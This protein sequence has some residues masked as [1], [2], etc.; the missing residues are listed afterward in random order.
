MSDELSDL[1]HTTTTEGAS[2]EFVA[3]LRRLLGEEMALART[4]TA[5]LNEHPEEVDDRDFEIV[6]TPTR[7]QVES[8]A[9][10]TRSS[11]WWMQIAAAMIG[12][13]VI[14][15]VLVSLNRSDSELDTVDIP[16]ETI[17][18]SPPPDVNSLGLD[19]EPTALTMTSSPF[20]EPATYQTSLIGTSLSFS[21]SS[22]LALSV[23]G[24]GFE[25]Q[26]IGGSTFGGRVLNF[27]RISAL[28]SPSELT[29]V[30]SAFE[31][32]VDDVSG[33]VEALDAGV[34]SDSPQETAVGGA[35]ATRIELQVS[36]FGCGRAAGCPVEFDGSLGER[37]VFDEGARYRVW[38]V[39]QGAEDALLVSAGINDASDES[40]FDEVDALLESVELGESLPN[41]V[42]SVDAGQQTM[43]RA[44]GGISLTASEAVFVDESTD[45]FAFVNFPT[46]RVSLSFIT[47]PLSV[48]GQQ[49]TTI[50]QLDAL[51]AQQAIDLTER[52]TVSADGVTFSAFQLGG[53]FST[54][55]L[56]LEQSELAQDSPG[57]NPGGSWFVAVDPDFGVF[58]VEALGANGSLLGD[59]LDFVDSLLASLEFRGER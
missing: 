56:V 33:W 36:E 9:T 35:A 22:E 32:P 29:Q 40:W 45:G 37:S 23:G 3:D 30:E 48:D 10:N 8:G 21:T 52:T 15:W 51:F 55:L 12:A 53:Q 14:A 44:F 1:V 16:D 18:D 58:I 7:V 28:P 54:P 27:R 5:V 26:A 25:L 38:I 31:W 19:G 13:L 50:E 20:L 2:A 34:L 41:P 57:W 47:S 39:N 42:R 24:G 6:L 4:S 17:E 43:L 11:V 59:E 49:I 46:E